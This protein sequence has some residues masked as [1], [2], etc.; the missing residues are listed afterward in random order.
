MTTELFNA[1]GI[2][3]KTEDNGVLIL[4]LT[5][6]DNYWIMP[7]IRYP[8]HKSRC[9]AERRRRQ[10]R[11]AQAGTAQRQGLSMPI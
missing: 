10:E 4:F 6:D 5:D 3:S 7:G 1:W 11:K 2:G 9:S 8:K